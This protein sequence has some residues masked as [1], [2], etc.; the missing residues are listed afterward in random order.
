MAYLIATSGDLAAGGMGQHDSIVAFDDQHAAAVNKYLRAD[1][2]FHRAAAVKKNWDQPA[3]LHRLVLETHS[4]FDALVALGI[5]DSKWQARTTWE[6]TSDQW[7]PA[8][9]N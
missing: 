2:A 7:T 1:R 5:F 4:E 9:E 3:K 6:V 8:E